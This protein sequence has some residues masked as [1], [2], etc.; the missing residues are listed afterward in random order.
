MKVFEEFHDHTNETLQNIVALERG[1]LE[2]AYEDEEEERRVTKAALVLREAQ[3]AAT[4]VQGLLNPDQGGSEIHS[5][6][7]A[8]RND[9]SFIHA[10]AHPNLTL[11]SVERVTFLAY[12][13]FRCFS[14][15]KK[16]GGAPS[17]GCAAAESANHAGRE[18]GL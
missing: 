4:E 3:G 14:S 10:H 1:D 17:T 2:E 15:S 13:L 12:F 9:H 11:L 8:G 7:G 5:H 18:L 16:S 6:E